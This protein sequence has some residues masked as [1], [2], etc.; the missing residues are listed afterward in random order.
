MLL[1][2]V[3]S[4]RCPAHEE[5]A[6]LVLAVESWMGPRI[7][8]GTL[9]CPICHSRYPI[10]HGAVEF[11]PGAESVRR[12]EA[13]V[14]PMRLAAQLSLTEP[15]G[16]ILLT[17][18]YTTVVEPL[19]SFGE[20]TFI[21]VDAAPSSLPLAVNLGVGDRLPFVNAALRAAAIDETRAADAFLAEVVRC[22]RNM[23]R[24]VMPSSGALPR[25]TRVLADDEHER[26]AEVMKE[27]QPIL[28]RR[29]PPASGL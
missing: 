9:G 29:A 6:S 15:G 7:S 10:H 26:V 25:Q 14:D 5:E 27:G 11:A 16:I 19:M 21:L 23:G 12:D 17:G 8:E 2:L 1:S 28:L 3:D 18:R 4:L 13:V 20:T 22:L 24:L